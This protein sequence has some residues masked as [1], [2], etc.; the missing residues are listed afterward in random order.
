MVGFE[1]SIKRSFDDNIYALVPP[2]GIVNINVSIPDLDTI[3][4]T[5]D[6]NAK[7]LLSVPPS[8]NMSLRVTGSR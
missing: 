8:P 2:Y 3:P 1:R 5:I 4:V 6:P 7:S